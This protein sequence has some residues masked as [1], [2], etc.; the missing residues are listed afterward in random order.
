MDIKIQNYNISRYAVPE[1]YKNYN[2]YLSSLSF[3]FESIK[4]FYSNIVIFRQIIKL[5]KKKLKQH[6][7]ITV[8][9]E[10]D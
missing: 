3:F 4:V 10:M 9:I 6:L 5:D 2:T 8:C 7:L 1:I